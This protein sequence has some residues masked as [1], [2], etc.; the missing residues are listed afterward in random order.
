MYEILPAPGELYPGEDWDPAPGDDIWNPQTWLD[1]GVPIRA[2]HLARA[3]E[4]HEMLAQ[5]DPQVPI[6]S[7][8]GALYNTPV[9][10]KGGL[11]GMFERLIDGAAG[12]DGTVP[13]TSA[14]RRASPNF[15][16]NEVHTEL[17]I[18]NAVIDGIRDWVEGGQ[19]DRL[20]KQVADVVP[21]DLPLRGASMTAEAQEAL[22]PGEIARKSLAGEPLDHAEL[23]ALHTI[24]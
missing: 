15:Y 5:A 1:Q 12:G 9:K 22:S 4:H 17:V 16:V 3:L 18:E 19:P 7:V 21:G 24:S 2:G 20:V 6:Y 13:V 8:I 14:M 23:A 10:L 11:R